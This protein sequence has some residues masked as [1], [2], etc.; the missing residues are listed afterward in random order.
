V[1]FQHQLSGA[2]IGIFYIYIYS[3]VAGP[4]AQRQR[5]QFTRFDYLFYA[6]VWF[7]INPRGISHRGE[8][9][10]DSVRVVVLLG[11]V[12]PMK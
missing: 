8:L 11:R 1:I 9:S 4:F 3:A 5:L 10:I 12:Q 6:S 7:D 2:G